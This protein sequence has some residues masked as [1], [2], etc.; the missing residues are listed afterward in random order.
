MKIGGKN[1]S[2]NRINFNYLKYKGKHY[3]SITRILN[4]FDVL[5]F[6]TANSVAESGK[7]QMIKDRAKELGMACKDYIYSSFIS[8]AEEKYNC[9]IVRSIYWLKYTNYLI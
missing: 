5:D 6:M 3:N 2:T 7:L 8:E 4:Y 1:N 9:K